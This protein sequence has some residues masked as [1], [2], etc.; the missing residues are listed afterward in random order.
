MTEL[1]RLADLTLLLKVIWPTCLFG[2]HTIT[3]GFDATGVAVDHGAGGHRVD[4]LDLA[5]VGNHGAIACTDQHLALCVVRTGDGVTN[6]CCL[7]A[8][9]NYMKNV[10]VV[11][12]GVPGTAAVVAPQTD[13]SGVIFRT[14]YDPITP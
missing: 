7:V 5:R 12:D 6:G 11:T 1:P 3:T 14:G 4:A 13:A 2:C 8:S 9:G 10:Q